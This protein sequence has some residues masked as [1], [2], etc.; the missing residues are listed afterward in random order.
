MSTDRGG[1]DPNIFYPEEGKDWWRGEI[2]THEEMNLAWFSEI[3]LF[4]LYTNFVLIPYSI[5][6]FWLRDHELPG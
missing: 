6:N 4:C 2:P 3:G 1:L 5:K